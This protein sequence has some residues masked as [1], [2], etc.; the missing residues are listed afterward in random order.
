[1]KRH[2]A[3][4][5]VSA[6]GKRRVVIFQREDGR[7]SFREDMRLESTRSEAWGPLWTPSPVCGTEEAA[8]KA[9]RVAIAWLRD[10]G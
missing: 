8:E 7:F 9:A 5:F 2:T 3:K 4:E 1:M 6:D 10:L